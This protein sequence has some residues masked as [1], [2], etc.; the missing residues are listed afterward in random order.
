VWR[1]LLLV[2]VGLCRQTVEEAVDKASLLL[3]LQGSL[4]ML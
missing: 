4:Q 2:V 3:V 1:A